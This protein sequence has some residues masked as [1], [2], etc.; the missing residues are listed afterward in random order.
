MKNL[1]IPIVSFIGLFLVFGCSGS[2]NPSPN[3]NPAVDPPEAAVLVFPNQNSECNEGTNFTDSE[4]DV[5]FNWSDAANATN[6]ELFL[7]NLNTQTTTSY[8]STASEITITILRGNPYSWY[9]V[10]KNTGTQTKQSTTWKFYNA[11][12]TI[13]SY[14]PFPAELVSPNM[15]TSFSNSTTNVDLKWNGADVDN[16]ITNYEIIFGTVNPPVTS[17]GVIT[18]TNMNVSVNS[19]NTYYWRV[20]TSDNQGNNSESEIFQFKV[21]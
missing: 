14:A 17:Q 9:I 21:D 16:D 11:G 13:T 20:I 10:S 6:Y 4:S 7:K 18:S 5:T 19:G 3:P 8:N 1:H 15:G 12:K 2:D